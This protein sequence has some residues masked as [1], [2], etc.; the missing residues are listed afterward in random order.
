MNFWSITMSSN[1]RDLVALTNEALAISITKNKSIIDTNTI[2]SA[3]HTQTWDLRSQDCC[4]NVLLSKCPIDPIFIYMKKKSC[5]E[6]YSYLYK[7]YFKL[8][9]SMKKRRSGGSSWTEKD[10]SQFD[11][12]RVTLLLRPEPRNPLYMMQNRSCSI[13]DQR[14][15]NEKYELEFEE[16]E[17]KGALDLQVIE[18]NLFNHLVWAPRISS[19]EQGFFRIRQFI[20]HPTNPLFF[21]FK[22][23]PPISVFS[24]LEFFA[25]EEM[26]K[27]LLNSLTDPPTYIYINVYL[28][29]RWIG[30]NSSLSNGSFHS[31][32]LSYSY[33]YLQNMFLSN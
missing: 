19:K 23:Q 17:V 4:T 6:R 15:F 21:L 7:W 2:R 18:E 27:G 26:S 29:Y 24:H 1:A 8:R 33:Q 3:L 5:N 20:W 25:D 12:D 22:D 14:F 13:V 30:T 28:E 32:T 9:T 10:S 31:N 16:G 11:N